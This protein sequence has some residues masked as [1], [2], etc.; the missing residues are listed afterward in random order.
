[1]SSR[2][3]LLRQRSLYQRSLVLLIASIVCLGLAGTPAAET[4]RAVDV[5]LVLAID[6]SYSVDAGEFELQKIGLAKAFT[7]PAVLAAILAGEHKAIGVTVVEWSGA[8]AQAVVIPWTTVHDPAS[9]VALA[10]RIE[11]MPRLT[12]EGATSI[13]SMIEFGLALF[14]ANRLAGVRRVIDISA[15]GRNNTG[16]RIGAV[17]PLATMLG[18]TVNGLAILNEIPTLH[19]YFEQQVISGPDAFVMA[20][21]DYEHY[22]VAILRKLIREIGYPAVS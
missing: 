2:H 18:V 17:A 14:D 16:H 8:G 22:A 20:A 9:A 5:E 21:D 7:N 19:F 4:F 12:Q 13:S 15:D 6:C 1:M 10:A 3:G 11:A